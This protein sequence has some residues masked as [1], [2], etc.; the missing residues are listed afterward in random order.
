MAIY[1]GH[2]EDATGNIILSIG[3]GITATLE[4]SSTA[5]QSYTKGAYLF[6][7]NRLCKASTNISSG[8]TLS[9]GT[10]LLETSVGEELTSHLRASDG[11][12]FYFDI[13]DNSYGYY[14]SAAKVASEFV[15]FGNEPELLYSN[16]SDGNYSVSSDY[17]STSYFFFVPTASNLAS[18]S[19]S[20]PSA[21]QHKDED[22]AVSINFSS[23]SNT[24][25]ISGL[26]KIVVAEEGQIWS[27][28]RIYGQ[29][30]GIK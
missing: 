11:S 3:N 22:I 2:N 24:V 17:T 1:K 5:S 10:N 18:D 21:N 12:E 9:I 15:K 4:S 7:N 16:I 26:F 6:F 29:L 25:S 30:W 27:S 23:S 20:S 8:T 13:K 19:G 28:M 14:P